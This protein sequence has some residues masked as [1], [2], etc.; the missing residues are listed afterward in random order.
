MSVPGSQEE[1][2]QVTQ[3]V[4]RTVEVPVPVEQIVEKVVERVQH[5]HVPVT[6]E[7]HVTIPVYS[8]QVVQVGSCPLSLP[9]FPPFDCPCLT[10]WYVVHSS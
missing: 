10:L 5:E 8:Q 6:R 1:V 3:E 9:H 2:Q 4:I 7:E